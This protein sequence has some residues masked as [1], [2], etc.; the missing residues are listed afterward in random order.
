M[1]G[2]IGS[3]FPLEA[4]SAGRAPG[5][6]RK[7]RDAAEKLG[8]SELFPEITI[9]PVTDDHLFLMER[10]FP[11]LDLIAMTPE[12]RFPP[13]WHTHQDTSEF[14]SRDV[15]HA[16]GMTTLKALWDDQ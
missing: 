5:V 1:V 12:G 3:I 13:E 7:L 10:G 2:R 14:I 8:Y 16:V 4:Y 9:G 15:L 6:M 11:V